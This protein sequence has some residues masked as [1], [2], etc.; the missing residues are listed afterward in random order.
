MFYKPHHEALK[1]RRLAS[2]TLS[3][4]SFAYH[5]VIVEELQYNIRGALS[6]NLWVS[7]NLHIIEN[8]SLVPGRV[9][10]CSQLLCCLTNMQEGHVC[11]WICEGKIGGLMFIILHLELAM[12]RFKLLAVSLV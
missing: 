5:L 7:M 10:R 8:Q 12:S 1:L 6:N 2:Q 3:P 4:C 11:I 9:Q